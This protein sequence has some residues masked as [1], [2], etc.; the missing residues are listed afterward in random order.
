MLGARYLN[1]Q[2]LHPQLP[3]QAEVLGGRTQPPSLR[4]SRETLLVLRFAGEDLPQQVL[5]DDP[6]AEKWRSGQRLRVHWARG[7]FGGRYITGWEPIIRP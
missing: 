1:G 5:S 2:A 6:A 7:R 3:L 4:S